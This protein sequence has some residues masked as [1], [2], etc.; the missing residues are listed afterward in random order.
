MTSSGDAKLTA[1]EAD[2]W[3][4]ILEQLHG[5]V[6]CSRRSR[7]AARAIGWFWT[8][9]RSCAMARGFDIGRLGERPPSSD[10]WS[11]RASVRP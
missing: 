7:V 3:G 11:W 10:G 4:Q 1:A 9:A 6:H 2:A 8:Y 5:E